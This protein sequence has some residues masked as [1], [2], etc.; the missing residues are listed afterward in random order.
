ML[1]FFIIILFIVVAV[2]SFRIGQISETKNLFEKDNLIEY[3]Q[4]QL[5]SLEKRLDELKTESAA[6]VKTTNTDISQDATVIN[7]SP[8]NTTNSKMKKSKK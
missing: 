7:T 1:T 6:K 4:H 3:L 5:D 2:A 8:V